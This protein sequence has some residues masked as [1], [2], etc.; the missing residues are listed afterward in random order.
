MPL[1]TIDATFENGVFVPAQ[2]PALADHERVRLMIEPLAAL[3]HHSEA[4]A[5]RRG[6]RIRLNPSLA[7]EIAVSP[8]F[9][10]NGN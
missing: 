7:R 2:R 1:N 6:R 9:H 4:I 3:P 5:R 8:E 10:P